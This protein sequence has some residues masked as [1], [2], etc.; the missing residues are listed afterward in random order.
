MVGGYSS[1]SNYQSVEAVSSNGT[2]LCTLPDLPDP[3]LYHTMDDH[4][5]CGGDA[6][7]SMSSCIHYVGG[8]WTQYRR[9]L[10]NKR[11]YHLSWKREDGQVVLIGG[12]NGESTKTSEVVANS[13]EQNGFELKYKTRHDFFT[14]FITLIA[15]K[16]HQI[17]L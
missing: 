3:R 2:H 1:F 7:E 8:L 6:K 13:G 4:I 17:C 5:L 10:Q 15:L 14:R 9:D 11:R 16:F 12:E